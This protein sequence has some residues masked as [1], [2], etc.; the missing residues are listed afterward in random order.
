MR[1]SKWREAIDRVSEVANR[2]SCTLE[3]LEQ[4]LGSLASE[5]EQ[6]NISALAYIATT[7]AK[8]CEAHCVDIA[9]ARFAVIDLCERLLN[10]M[11]SSR[12]FD[13]CNASSTLLALLF[14]ADDEPSLESTASDSTTPVTNSTAAE[15]A[16]QHKTELCLCDDEQLLK[17]FLSEATEHIQDAEQLMLSLE[18]NHLDKESIN[19]LFRAVHSIKGSAGVLELQ[20]LGKI[21]HLAESV[22]VRVRDGKIAIRGS[23]FDVTLAAV[24][25]M[26]AQI[27]SLSDCHQLGRKIEYP[28]PPTL[29]LNC[30]ENIRITGQCSNEEVSK[31]KRTLAKPE[32]EGVKKESKAPPLADTL[33]VDGKRL[34]QLIDLIGELVITDAMVQRELHS[35]EN[36]IASSVALRLRKVVRE[37]QQLSLTLKMVP[38]GTVF[39]KMN[40]LVR[41]VSAKLGKQVELKIVGGD[42]EVDK[43]LLECVSDPLVHLIRN[44]LDHGIETT[45]AERVAAGKPAV[46]SIRLQAEHRAGS[47]HIH[48]SDDGRGLNRKRIV[49]R[50]VERGLIDASAT[51][52]ESEVDELIFAPGFS[53]ATEVTELSGRGVG[54]DV[55]RKNVESMRGSITLSSRPGM[56]TDVSLELPLTLSIIDGTVVRNGERY[57]IIPTL[58]VVEQVQFGSL[59]FSGSD[60]CEL[61]RFRARFLSVKRLG[62]VL[63]TPHSKTLKH[64]QVVV[65]IESSGKQHA[66]IVDEVLGQQPVVIK[67]LGSVLAGV[68]YFAGG[69]LLSDGQIGFVLDLT[70]VCK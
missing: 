39:Q 44:S 32:V 40:R 17:A 65:I 66:L 42:T 6:D 24:D 56:G 15:C 34:E 5:F 19:G 4:S 14:P 50:A 33:R 60:E 51:L 10:A 9:S 55:V 45:T 8:S 54:M 69:A 38:I 64:G 43:T 57:F 49:D 62:E 68:G 27:R 61:V 16:P 52:S 48:I 28:I 41:D 30:L 13:F 7:A 53:T 18:N 67:P 59:E 31:L 46:A 26:A 3:G 35:R 11:Q 23:A 12:P 47:I 1:S 58:A 36:V 70:A 63:G 21:S 37:V 25:A 29:L 2:E 20:S 22:L